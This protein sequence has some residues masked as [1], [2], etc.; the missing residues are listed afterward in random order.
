MGLTITFRRGTTAQVNAITPVAG[1]PTFETDYLR[2]A[3]GDGV[4]A[5][6]LK[7]GPTAVIEH[8]TA[9][10]TL[11]K[12]E[13]GSIHTNLGAGGAVTLVLPQDA[14]AGTRFH[15]AVMAA[16]ELRIDPGAAGAIYINGAKQTDDSY[17]WADD[18]G[19]SVMLVC[20]GNGDWISLYTTGTWGVV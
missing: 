19:E 10:D 11:T 16:F 12:E 2:M 1:E 3:I 15:L 4:T 7:I 8:H 20:D 5:G 13:S 17:I 6:G 14:V 18:E 9:G